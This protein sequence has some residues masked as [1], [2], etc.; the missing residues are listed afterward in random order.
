M[1][2]LNIP[3]HKAFTDFAIAKPLLFQ[4]LAFTKTNKHLLIPDTGERYP[5]IARIHNSAT[6]SD[7]FLVPESVRE[8]FN[9]KNI[10][11]AIDIK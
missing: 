10:L 6:H 5:C 9:E 7:V 2:P 1:K 4:P 11:Y 3:V 8:S